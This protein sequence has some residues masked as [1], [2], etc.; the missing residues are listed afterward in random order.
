MI[1]IIVKTLK[2]EKNMSGITP[3]ML[4]NRRANLLKHLAKTGP[5]IT[6]AFTRIGRKCGNAKC[7]CAQGGEKHPAYLLTFKEQGKTKSL[8]VPMDMVKT[9]EQWSKEAKWLKQRIQAMNQ[10]QRQI[11][12]QYVQRKRAENKGKRRIRKILETS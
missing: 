3:K 5:F 11:I 8:Y 7:P 2:K 10:I 4:E 12:G 6:D 9:V 1:R